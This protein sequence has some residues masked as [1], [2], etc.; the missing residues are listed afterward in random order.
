M[1]IPHR[2]LF[3]LALLAPLAVAQEDEADPNVLIDE[4]LY[5]A[6]DYRMIGPHRGGR[7]TAVCGVRQEPFTYY[8]G[9]T[10]GGV[11][12]TTNAGRT[13]N[14]VSDGFLRVGSIGAVAV[15]DSD[16]NV[17][18]VG[19]GSA[20]PRGNV[21]AGDGMY[22]STDA[23]RTWS[24]A[25]LEDAGQIAR[26]R[27]HPTDPDIAWVAALGHAFG[28]NHQ[29]GVFRTTDGGATWEHVLFVSEETGACD[30]SLNPGN[31]RELYA[32]AWRA[33]R[34]P[35]TMIDGGDEGGL[36]KSTDGGDT[37]TRL[38]GGLPDGL[39]GRIGVAVSPARPDRVWAL[40]TTPEKEDGGL[41]RSDDAGDSWTRV[42]PDRELQTRGWYYTH[43]F[44]HPT[45]PDT[46][47]SLNVDLLRSVD[48]GATFES[49]D[50]P[51]ADH[52]DLWIHPEQPE[53]LIEGNDGGAV[54]SLD[55]METWSSLYN[56]PTAE[57]YRV[58]VDRRPPYRVYA[59]QQD[60][61]TISVPKALP[62]GVSAQSHWELVGGGESGH[63][64]VHPEDP[65]LTYGGNYIG[66][67][68][69]HDHVTGLVR[70]VVVYPELADGV[71]PRDMT[72]RFQWN[73]PIVFSPHDP[74]LLYHASN[75]VH[76]TR[77]GGMTWETIS[78]DLSHD[79]ESKQALPGGPIQH[80]FSGVEVYGT[81]FALAE[82]PQTRGTIWAGTDDGRIHLT[83]DD[84]VSWQDV[85]PPGLPVDSTVDTIALSPHADGRAFA[86]VQRYRMDDFRPYA[87]RTDDFGATWTRIADGTN[88]IPAHHPVRV[89][90]ED[91]WRRGLLYAGT[92]YGVFV[93]FDDAAHWQSLQLDLP[94]VQVPDLVV[95]EGD[96]VLATHGRS[97]WVLDD[98]SPLRE[99]TP[100]LAAADVHLFTP[101][102]ATRV[103]RGG[104]DGEATPERAPGGALLHWWL[105][106]EPED[107]LR[108]EVLD[109]AGELVRAFTS[110]V[111]ED[112]DAEPLPAE[113]G[114]NR[115]AWDLFTEELDIVDDA[116]MSLGYD[117][118]S[119][120]L[121]GTYTVR[122]TVGDAARE[123]P[124]HVE[125]DPRLLLTVTPDDLRANDALVQRLRERIHAI[126]AAVRTIRSVRGQLDDLAARAEAAG[127]EA[128]LS[129]EAEPLVLALTAVEEDLMQT[130]NEASN[131]ALNFPP[132][133]DNQLVYLYG[134]VVES[135]GRPTE[136]AY[137]RADD[138]EV[139]LATHLARLDDLL[140]V[141][142]AGFE[143]R[144]R[145][146]GLPVV[147]VPAPDSDR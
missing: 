111:D 69:R 102:F 71:A 117:G 104:Y 124:L 57:F 46:V 48:G 144:V 28:P 147:L 13:W 43:V 97:F 139:E 61:T 25:G 8:M 135:I 73:A 116:V 122:L 92:E 4:R 129:A 90:R 118:G 44:A 85:T 126:T 1:P 38:G 142:L 94:A 10:G 29:R 134:H 24:H 53:L 17:V 79:D 3:A 89:I 49:L 112:D 23:G 15:A 143:A 109:A 106:E 7:V 114:L 16:P 70:D 37:W 72:Y 11:W 33:E 87:F 130:R 45:D 68:Y 80:D 20:C 74:E 132:K 113:A 99:L 50:A 127:V 107:E 81:V 36:F 64:A 84:G 145:E 22:R 105:A 56:Q 120:V 128:D 115:F 39:L 88:G 19:T 125:L 67:I 65:N 131:D 77:D 86:A 42:S 5:D 30:L 47:Y 138:L 103:V 51:H 141:D 93:S 54:V 58:A 110:E 55:G 9:A 40:F 35:W 91:P 137:R 6:L 83:R 60:N 133:L 41:Y 31:P 2:A 52:H 98:V 123:V 108:L 66:Q 95:H 96:L 146:L 21:I 100:E 119:W 121:P 14:N 62:G 136:G 140:A 26:V 27:V 32:A 63:V 12:K 82:S 101:R 78:P 18:W 75:H 34:K 76:R 59:S